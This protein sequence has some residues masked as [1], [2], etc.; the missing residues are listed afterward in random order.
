MNMH[1]LRCTSTEYNTDHTRVSEP[2]ELV[3]KTITGSSKLYSHTVG[4]AFADGTFF[5]AKAVEG[6]FSDDEP[7]IDMRHELPE[8]SEALQM[9][10]IDQAEY[11]RCLAEQVAEREKY[12]KAEFERLRAKFEGGR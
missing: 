4:I 5:Y 7:D 8:A 2:A 3:G 6:S 1:N 10:I 12:E 9:G 11:D